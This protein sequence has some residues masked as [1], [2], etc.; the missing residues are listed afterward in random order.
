MYIAN[1]SWQKLLKIS[2]SRGGMSNRVSHW[3]VSE[4]GLLERLLRKVSEKPR[5]V[6][7]WQKPRWG[8]LRHK[9][10][11]LGFWVKP[12]QDQA[13]QGEHLG[14]HWCWSEGSG[15]EA[16]SP[17]SPGWNRITV[18]PS[19]GDK[20]WEEWK[21]HSGHGRGSCWQVHM[22]YTSC[23]L[24]KT[25]VT[26]HPSRGKRGC[27]PDISDLTYRSLNARSKRLRKAG[28]LI[29]PFPPVNRNSSKSP[30]TPELRYHQGE[31]GGGHNP[32]WDL[33]PTDINE[34]S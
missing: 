11:P 28:D 34:E 13:F 20:M 18:K 26:I 6:R 27:L 2:Y 3:W 9:A 7:S 4:K 17:A 10:L 14:K 25:V 5:E 16:S 29:C 23:G 22:G 15:R 31:E 30:P 8:T 21:G 1:Y 12:V 33:F 32:E 19:S 24:W